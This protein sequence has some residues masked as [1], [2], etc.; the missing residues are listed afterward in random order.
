MKT[1]I[2]N[3]TL[4]ALMAGGVMSCKQEIITFD[5][6][7]TVTPPT[8]TKGTADFTKYVSLGNSLTAGYQAGALFTE[9]QQN[10]FPL[11]LSKQFS[12]AQGST[13]TFNQPDINSVNGYNSA[14]SNPGAGVILGRLV[15]FAAD[16]VQAHAVPTPAGYPGVPSPYNTADVPSAYTGD[17]SKLNNFGVPGILLG[18][19][20]IPQ[21]GGPSSGNPYFN[22]LYA[23]FASNPGTSTII[24]DAIA[25]QP[26]FFTFDLG[27][28]D[29]LGYATTG[30]DGSIG[31]T[32]HANFLSY[33]TNA[34]GA[35]MT[36]TSANGVVATIPNVTTIPFFYTI[37]WNA[38]PL[39]ATT[40]TALMDPATGFGG[41]NAILD[42]IISNSALLT[43]FGLS[44]AELTSRKVSYTASAN[45]PILI[46]DETLK[47]LGPVL[48][49]MKSV[50]AITAA[51]RTAMTP[52]QMIRQT[53]STD[54]IPL[55]AG[56][57]LG[58]K[59][60]NNPLYINGVTIPLADKYVLIPS[61]TAAILTAT[62][63]FNATIS[64]VASGFSS[65]IAVADINTAFTSFVTN[66]AIISDG[67]MITPTFTPPFG[68]FSEDGVHPNS[69]G[70]AYM[71]NIFID[72]INA[73]FG[74]NIPHASL[75]DYKG[76]GLPL[77]P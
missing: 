29:V 32:S 28:N 43:N 39:D 71:A 4:A 30:G 56:G 12:I 74:A 21:T 69:R 27:N 48:D 3:I 31:L 2:K 54:L 22:P 38:V 6:P 5:K 14:Y 66:Q 45:N 58:T 41:Y 8:Y 35:L 10:S 47:D 52:Y 33:Y 59:V 44:A 67:V 40:A 18:Q 15:L 20:L 77:F 46:T 73:K 7:A 36:N 34:I 24:G 49:Y 53:T 19:A 75:A 57:I 23:R 76:V 65:R 1:I 25:T 16:G 17:K 26:T 50:G 51:Q 63:D 72:A 11:I 62:A 13:I 61:E 9:G 68:A 60:N 55:T 42:G 37:K 64:S 70:Y